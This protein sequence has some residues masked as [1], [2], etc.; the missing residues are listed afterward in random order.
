[1]LVLGTVQRGSAPARSH[2]LVCPCPRSSPSPSGTHSHQPLCSPSNS[3]SPAQVDGS[4]TS[5]PSSG[6]D[7]PPGVILSGSEQ[8]Y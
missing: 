2:S 6:C 3:P 8:G 1:M 5:D 7:P 4:I